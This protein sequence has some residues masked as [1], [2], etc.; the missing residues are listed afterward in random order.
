MTRPILLAALLAVL[1]GCATS[2]GSVRPMA[3][4]SVLFSHLSCQD[5]AIVSASTTVAL[6]K[7]WRQQKST[8]SGDA[9][10]MFLIGLPVSSMG[11]G[12][13]EHSLAQHLGEAKAIDRVSE[14][15]GCGFKFEYPDVVTKQRNRPTRRRGPAGRR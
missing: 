2:P 7:A 4:S 1:T 6:D 9:L 10:G 12:D 15:K 13:V 11:G 8:A 3:V 14:Q 5:L